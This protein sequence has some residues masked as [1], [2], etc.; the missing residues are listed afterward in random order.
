VAALNTRKGDLAKSLTLQANALVA[1]Y[2]AQ[3]GLFGGTD[4]NEPTGLTQQFN[5]GTSSLLNLLS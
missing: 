3:S 5:S 2:T 1:Q 4:S